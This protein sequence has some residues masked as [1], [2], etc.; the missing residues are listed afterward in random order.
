M[1][2]SIVNIYSHS[3]SGV[4][5][6]SHCI[7]DNLCCPLVILGFLGA[8]RTEKGGEV[9]EQKG[10][11]C[12]TFVAKLLEQRFRVIPLLCR[13]SPPSAWGRNSW[14]FL[15]T[16]NHK[17]FQICLLQINPGNKSE[18]QDLDLGSVGTNKE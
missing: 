5:L 16:N 13:L 2:I 4:L 10:S 9:C 6:W 14:A 8:A 18:T 3:T 12:A 1:I 7:K 11:A 17:A 15:Q